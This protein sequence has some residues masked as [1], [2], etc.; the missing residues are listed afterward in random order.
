MS[1]A[2]WMALPAVTVAV[3]AVVLWWPHIRDE[4]FVLL[5]SRAEGA[6]WYGAW[7]GFFGAIQPTLAGT[8]VLIWWHH[9]CHHSPWCLR[10]GKYEAAGGIFR[11]CAVH[12]PDMQGTRPHRDLIHRLHREHQERRAGK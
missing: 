2:R 8:A 11:L 12:H 10:W 1:R 4:T 7:S 6:G 5:G 3:A 9:T